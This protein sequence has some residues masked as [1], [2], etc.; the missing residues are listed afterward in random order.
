MLSK[1]RTDYDIVDYVL[2]LR[3]TGNLCKV[4]TEDN[5]VNK[6]PSIICSMGIKKK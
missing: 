6:Q 1:K 2:E 5:G 3:R 4:D